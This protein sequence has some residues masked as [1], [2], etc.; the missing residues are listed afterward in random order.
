MTLKLEVGKR[1][2]RRDGFVTAP[3]TK[4]PISAGYP[5]WD[6]KEEN[7]YTEDGAFFSSGSESR[8][9]LVAEYVE[10]ETA[11]APQSLTAEAEK[12]VNGQRQ[13]A[14]GTPEDNFERIARFWSAYFKNTGRE[15]EF[16]AADV[17]PMMR[18]LKEAR[19]CA[20][21]DH[22]DSHVDIIGYTL[23]G[24]RINKIA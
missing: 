3:L 2:I 12:I 10:P 23:T 24:A 14:Y 17:S 22:R 19:L 20:T 1:Y 9:D 7:S 4:N 5:F 11:A 18:L 8:R 16:T 21:P 15:I 6:P 13:T